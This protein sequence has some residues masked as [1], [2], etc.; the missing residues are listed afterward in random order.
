MRI[1]FYGIAVISLICLTFVSC[2]DLT[3]EIVIN[4]VSFKS[5]QID[6]SGMVFIPAGEF[7][8][9]MDDSI[10]GHHHGGS[11]HAHHDHH[12][13]KDVDFGRPAHKVYLDS[14]YIDKYEVTNSKYNEF[15][16]AGGYN[17]P[18]FWTEQGWRWRIEND[19]T[20]PNWWSA[21]K[22]ANY[23]SSPDYPDHPVAG[24]SWYEAMAYARWTGKSLPTEAQWEKAARGV[25]VGNIYPWGCDEPDCLFANFCV[26]K[27][28]F[29]V[30]SASVVGSFEKGKS[31][32]GVY[33]M[34]GNVWEWCKDWYSPSYY[35]DAPYKNPEC[36]DAG[37][38]KVLRGGSWVNA[39]EFIRSTFRQKTDPRLRNYFNGF[40]CVVEI[41]SD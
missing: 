13:H 6:L 18:Q 1:K 36:T 35:T 21:D 22:G 17:D 3:K 31:P 38:K 7:I 5:G 10:A 39:K 33:D 14:Y 2:A 37:T 9:G 25:D 19:I 15:I 12:G 27:H 4:N 29:C 28:K 24:I 26:E 20:E 11:D 30:G 16:Q 23:K 40:R 8:M 34:A 32:Y 41:K